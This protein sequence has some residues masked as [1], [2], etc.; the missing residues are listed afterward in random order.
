M[1]ASGVLVY[2]NKTTSALRIAETDYV[3]GK[4][5]VVRHLSAFSWFIFP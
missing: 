1:N 2:E 4:V 3:T 5:G